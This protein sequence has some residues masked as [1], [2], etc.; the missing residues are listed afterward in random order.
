MKLRFIPNG[1]AMPLQPGVLLFQGQPKR[2]IGRTFDPATKTH[3]LG[4]PYECDSDS[5]EAYRCK[6]FLRRGEVLPAD[7]ATA[8]AC[9]VSFTQPKPAAVEKSARSDKTTENNQ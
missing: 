8:D 4:D 9:G 1:D 3:P 2:Y 7:K 6:V 5:P